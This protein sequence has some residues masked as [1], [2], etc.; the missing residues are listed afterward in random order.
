MIR[1][2]YVATI[3]MLGLSGLLMESEAR[4]IDEDSADK[5]QRVFRVLLETSMEPATLNECQRRSPNLPR[6]DGVV[7]FQNGSMTPYHHRTC[8]YAK[9]QP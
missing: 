8:F 9:A 4:A 2:F 1:T 6:A 7:S 5:V 3:L